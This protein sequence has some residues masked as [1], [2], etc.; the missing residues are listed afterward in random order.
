MPKRRGTSGK[1]SVFWNVPKLINRLGGIEPAVDAHRA[2][3]FVPLTY[4]QVSMWR[5][6]G[7]APAERL[8]ELFAVLRHIEGNRVDLWDYVQEQER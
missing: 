3:G 5:L 1:A 6:R 8:V 4:K 7:K 2:Y